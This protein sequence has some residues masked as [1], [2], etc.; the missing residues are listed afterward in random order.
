[1]ITLIVGAVVCL[2]GW[3]I[4]LKLWPFARCRRCD[5]SGRNEGSNRK[6]WGYCRKCDGSGRRER[7]GLHWFETRTD[8]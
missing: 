8:R 5:G 4:S 1:M 3:R 7:F 2:V 6:R